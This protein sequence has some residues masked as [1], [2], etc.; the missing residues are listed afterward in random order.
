MDT[1]ITRICTQLCGTAAALISLITLAVAN[2][3]DFD[4]TG[5]QALA[6]LA[7]CYGSAAL[8]AWIFSKVPPKP[9]QLEDT[10]TE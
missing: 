5:L 6:L 10:K 8:S 2:I 3:D 1:T 4:P 7:T 9:S